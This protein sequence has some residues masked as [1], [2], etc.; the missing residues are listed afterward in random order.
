MNLGSWVAVCQGLEWRRVPNMYNSSIQW[1]CVLMGSC[2]VL[3]RSIA[4]AV[5]Y[6]V[7]IRLAYGPAYNGMMSSCIAKI[8]ASPVRILKAPP[9]MWWLW[10]IRQAALPRPLDSTIPLLCQFH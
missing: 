1:D 3:D 8:R 4:L 2:S 6:I 10:T 7:C 9:T 5:A